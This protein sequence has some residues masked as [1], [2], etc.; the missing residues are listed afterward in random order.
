[1]L[2]I[3]PIL[4]ILLFTNIT[5]IGQ[6]F[7]YTF[8][9]PCTKE[10]TQFNLPIQSG[11]GSLVS[12]LGQ[13]KYFTADDVISGVF[14][15]WINQVYTEYRRLTPCSIQTT[16]IIRNQITSQI[17]GNT[18]QS[19]VGSIMGQV[20]A[21]SGMLVNTDLS[22]NS[23]EKTSKNE[24]NEKKSNS[25]PPPTISTSGVP[26]PSTF[27]SS[28]F[29]S[30]NTP[31]PT[32]T[33]QGGG[34]STTSTTKVGGNSTTS[35]TKVGGNS[36]TS[37]TQGGGNSTTSTTKSGGNS[38]TSTTKSGGQTGGQGS[39]NNTTKT[40]GN[41]GPSV[42]NNSTTTETTNTSTTSNSTNTQETTKS[43]GGQTGGQTGSETG[44]ETGGQG[45]EVAVTTTMT[46]DANNDK[47]SG[48]SKGGGKSNSRSNPIIVSSDLTSAQNMDRSF[49]PIINVGMSQSSMT[50][51]SSWGLNSMI[52]LNFKQF[53]LTGRYT[54][55]HFSKNKKLKLIHNLNLTGVYSY[56][57]LMSF[58]GYSMILNAGKYGITGFNVSGSITKSPEDV[59]LYLSPAMTAFYT[60][61]FKVGKR[62]ILSPE[63]YVISTP[64]MYSSV[65]KV[66]VSD[67]TFSA[68]IGTSVDYQFTKRFKVN[69]N[70][71]LNTS[72]NPDFPVLSFF[73]IGSKINL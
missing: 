59:N 62:M 42:K 54:K 48:G 71:K 43:E 31:S 39:G 26:F 21:E 36:T 51:T 10:I 50:G 65:D 9:D 13:Q 19:V 34:N 57:N 4:L 16:T 63:L 37:T 24:K 52:W 64:L 14:A 8:V 47:G 41:G 22:S 23:D 35:T 55:M 70:Y 53:A 5:A 38:T 25:Q 32:S 7:T 30:N 27:N 60:K 2:K 72:T 68:F 33:T 28:V 17:I 3:L 46:T 69:M 11:N 67:R 56:G 61:P 6:T 1:M 45:S 20:N 15:T 73:L 29:S 58:L 44:S 40:E 18:I 66:S 12:F 49:T